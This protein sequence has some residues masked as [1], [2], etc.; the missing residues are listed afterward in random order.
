MLKLNQKNCRLH[1]GA[2][3][4]IKTVG[5]LGAGIMG[6]GIAQAA[7]YAGYKVILKDIEQKFVDSG[8]KQNQAAFRQFGQPP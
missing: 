7:A 8:I 3:P 1:V 5:V 4:E 6:A 2:L